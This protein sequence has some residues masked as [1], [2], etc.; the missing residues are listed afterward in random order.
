MQGLD[1][2]LHV[3]RPPDRGYAETLTRRCQADRYF[4]G[5]DPGAFVDRFIGLDGKVIVLTGVEGQILFADLDGVI[6]SLFGRFE[7]LDLIARN[8]V[9]AVNKAFTLCSEITRQKTP[10][11][12]VPTGFPSKRIVVQPCNRGA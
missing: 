10:A 5:G 9:G 11:S 2:G 8:A 6:E 7:F 3:T 12:G 1:H 4:R